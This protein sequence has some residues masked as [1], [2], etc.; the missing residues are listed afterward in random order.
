M[1]RTLIKQIYIYLICAICTCVGI[2]FMIRGIFG[3]ARITVPKFTIPKNEW[4]RITSFEI[5]KEN[6]Y[7]E[8]KELE[9]S[10]KVLRKNWENEKLLTLE[11]EK[12]RGFLDIV[13]MITGLIITIPLFIIH[14]KM[15]K[16]ID[17]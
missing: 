9:L 8:I 2:I 7:K 10:E 13:H 14:W 15:L 11:G 6:R 1:K 17:E 16:K 5:Y 3:I 4:K 12:R